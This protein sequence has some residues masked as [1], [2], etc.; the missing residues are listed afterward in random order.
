[1][2]LSS[3]GDEVNIINYNESSSNVVQNKIKEISKV[4]IKNKLSYQG[5]C[6][7]VK[8]MN[9]MPG[10]SIKLP[11]CKKSLQKLSPG[12]TIGEPIYLV[13]CETCDE[14]VANGEN[15]PICNI[16]AKKVS[17]KN[18]FLVHFPLLPQ[19]C[20][21]LKLNL[22]EIIKYLHREHNEHM[23]S[24]VDDG[25]LYQILRKNYGQ[26]LITF[27]LNT[28][29][30]SVHKSSR[31]SLWPVQLYVNC[32]PPSIRFLSENVIVTTLYYGKTKPDMTTLLFPL[33]KELEDID[34]EPISICTSDNEIIVFKTVISMIASDLPARA[35]IQ[36]FIG[37]TGK[38]GCPCCY[39]PGIPIKNA[40]GKNTTIRF[41]NQN[42]IKLRTHDETIELMRCTF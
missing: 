41:I 11:E 28:D 5:V 38:H 40:S 29:G 30:A 12:T 33:A 20:R 16:I 8:L 24:D 7:V 13:L 19:I 32:L 27:T 2:N 22:D 31:F 9:D 17:K 21:I 37:H 14:L 15:C 4:Q 10:S 36:N 18:N 6:S 35:A 26:E 25:Q 23:L 1:M 39:H 34:K 3:E 42:N